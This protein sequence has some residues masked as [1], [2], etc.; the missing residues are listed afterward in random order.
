[1]L[2]A[3]GGAVVGRS[4]VGRRVAGWVALRRRGWTVLQLAPLWSPA[5]C[6]LVTV[7]AFYGTTRFRALAEPAFVVLAAAALTTRS[8]VRPLREERP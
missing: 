7:V 1:M 8:L 6:V 2:L 3:G 5:A 4:G